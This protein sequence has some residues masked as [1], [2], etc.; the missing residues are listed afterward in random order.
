MWRQV[1]GEPR[2]SGGFDHRHIVSGTKASPSPAPGSNDF[3]VTVPSQFQTAQNSRS[4]LLRRNFGPA[5]P[6]ILCF[7]RI[8]R[9]FTDILGVIANPLQVSRDENEIHVVGYPLRM[10]GPSFRKFVCP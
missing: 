1:K 2:R 3:S 9:F 5:V 10:Y 7:R 6:N 4:G 8:D